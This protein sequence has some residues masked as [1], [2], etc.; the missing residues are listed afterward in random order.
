[1]RVFQVFPT[2]ILYALLHK[3]CKQYRDTCDNTSDIFGR[4]QEQVPARRPAMLTEVSL[5]VSQYLLNLDY[6][7]VLVKPLPLACSFDAE[8]PQLMPL[9]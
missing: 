8:Y 6:Y 1:M 2:K 4:Y 7:S 3:F 9:S 5:D